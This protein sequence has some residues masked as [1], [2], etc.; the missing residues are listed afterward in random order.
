[1][2]ELVKL[3]SEEEG[4]RAI[5]ALHGSMYDVEET[6]ESARTIWNKMTDNEQETTMIFHS[7][8]LIS[9]RC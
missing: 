3:Y 8:L 9:K 7:L 4:I 2:A 5:I 1:M 6:R